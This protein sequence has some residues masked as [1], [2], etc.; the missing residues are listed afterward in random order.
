MKKICNMQKKKP[1]FLS[2]LKTSSHKCA[3]KRLLLHHHLFAVLDIQALGCGFGYAASTHV[4]PF[5]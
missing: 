1:I 2:P 4:V 5:V 3:E